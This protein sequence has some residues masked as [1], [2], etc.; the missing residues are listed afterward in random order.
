M[1]WNMLP[2]ERPGEARLTPPSPAGKRFP[3]LDLQKHKDKRALVKTTAIERA[4]QRGGL[5]K[6]LE[7][8]DD[9]D[10]ADAGNATSAAEGR[11]FG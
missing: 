4:A 8:G 1:V 10:A 3:G 5:K 6:A 2:H 9:E 11:P 7:S